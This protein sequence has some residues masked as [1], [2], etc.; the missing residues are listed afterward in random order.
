MVCI[1]CSWYVETD[2]TILCNQRSL[3]SS[4]SYESG[5]HNKLLNYP[6]FLLTPTPPVV[7]LLKQTKQM[8]PLATI[9]LQRVGEARHIQT[10]T[11]CEQKRINRL[12]IDV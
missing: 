12:V 10:E 4:V 5:Y 2:D 7:P 9:A 3:V 6:T 11:T 1:C 8:S